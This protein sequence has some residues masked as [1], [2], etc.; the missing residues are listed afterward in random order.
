MVQK[1]RKGI[2]KERKTHVLGEQ[3]FNIDSDLLDSDATFQ[4]LLV[5][6]ATMSDDDGNK[7]T[8]LTITPNKISIPS[9]KQNG[10][11]SA[12]TTPNLGAFIYTT[13]V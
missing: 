12:S 6:M 3:K 1:G 8:K 4:S 13:I 9:S 10:R 5:D 2:D 7:P 11:S